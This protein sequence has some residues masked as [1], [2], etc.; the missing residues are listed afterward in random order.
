MIDVAVSAKKNCTGGVVARAYAPAIVSKCSS[1]GTITAYRNVGGVVGYTDSSISITDSYTTMDV[2]AANQGAGGVV[3]SMTVN[4]QSNEIKLVN[5]YSAGNVSAPFSIGGIAGLLNITGAAPGIN[6]IVENSY[7][8]GASLKVTNPGPTNY[9]SGAIVGCFREDNHAAETAIKPVFSLKACYRRA[10]LDFA[11]YVG[12]YPDK[13]AGPVEYN[14]PLVDH[15]DFVGE[16][17]YPPHLVP[18]DQGYTNAACKCC[19]HGK[20][21][22]AGATVSSLAKAAGWDETVWD[23]SGNLPVLKK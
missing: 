17:A 5:T 2:S 22:A 21:A 10:D 11:D 13:T 6:V 15:E 9:S 8:F 7:Y 19:Y 12:L 18:Q 16:N 3:G 4:A 1:V 14:N 20:A 23:L